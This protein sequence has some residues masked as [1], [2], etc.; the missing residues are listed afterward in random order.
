L[1]EIVIGVDV[2]GRKADYDPRNDPVVR[3]EAAKLRARL[4]EYYAGPGK[5]QP[6][7]ASVSRWPIA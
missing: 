7:T 1:K 4:A 3:M 5:K 6:A 2:F